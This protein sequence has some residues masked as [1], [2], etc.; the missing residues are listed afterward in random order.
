M[1]IIHVSTRTDTAIVEI[2][3]KLIALTIAAFLK[4]RGE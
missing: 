4:L 2:N 1:R 3:G